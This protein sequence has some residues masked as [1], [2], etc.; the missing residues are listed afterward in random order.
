M[1][2]ASIDIGS[3]TVLLLIAE[4]NRSNYLQPIINLY[5]S[6]RISQGLT[7]A[8]TITDYKIN[9]LIMVLDEYYT[10][11]KKYCCDKVL[12]VGTNA[13]RIAS[14]SQKIIDLIKE[15]YGW[16]INIIDG[17]EEARL[18]Y[19]GTIFPFIDQNKKNTI[20]DIGGGST[21]I[22]KGINFGIDYSKSFKIGVVSLTEMFF[23][24][25]PPSYQQI[26]KAKSFLYYEFKELESTIDTSS[27]LIA[28]AGT[29]TTLACIKLNIKDYNE[30]LIDESILNLDDINYISSKLSLMNP[31]QVFQN[32]G[33]VVK[34]REDILFAGTL[35]LKTILETTHN[36]KIIVSTKGLRYGVLIDYII[37]E[38]N[39]LNE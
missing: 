34:G 31:K 17:M 29:P 4:Y 28:V 32:Y 7:N 23:R 10:L 15:K 19:Y 6:P 26:E 25:Y 2:L 12:L 30:N 33:N 1:N 27:T 39:N 18:S 21:E 35:I 37:T 8:N 20:I 36:N 3:N 13:L 14:N 24:H 11:T 9:E 5:H 16:D 22:I 38:L